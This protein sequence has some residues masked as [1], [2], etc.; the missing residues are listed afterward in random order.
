MHILIIPGYGNSGPQHWQSLWQEA[1]PNSSRFAPNSWDNP[2]RND[3]VAALENSVAALGPDTILVAHSLG[4]LTTAHWAAQTQLRVKAALLVA[5]P[6]PSSTH[7]P[8][9]I[10]GFE[11]PPMQP[12]PFA[13][14]LVAS[15]DDPYA[16]LAFS[17]QCAAAWGSDFIEIGAAGHIN[18]DS[19]F[20]AWPEGLRLLEQ[21]A[22]V[23]PQP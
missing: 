22:K 1:R 10:S 8:A 4:C 20:G 11:N 7:F 9:A 15:N 23:S 21:L 16:S 14:I 2:L 5:V 3:W 13:S 18:A 12:L 19:G 17:R 6:D